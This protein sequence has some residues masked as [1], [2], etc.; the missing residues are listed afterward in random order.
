MLR[1]I[2]IFIL[3]LFPW[4]VSS[5]VISDYSY[6]NKLV[7]PFFAFNNLFYTISWTL[8]YIF[9][10]VSMCCLFGNYKFKD[11]PKS[12]K[13]SLIINYLFNQG[14]TLVFFGLK[15]NFLGF[16]F[17]LGTFVSSLFLFEEAN[18][19]IDCKSKLLYPN[20]ILS[21]YATILSL[22]IYFMNI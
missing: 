13:W 6:Y 22:T 21:L 16:V 15:N 18:Q 14:F 8:V 7:L 2:F 4:F 12:Y 17:C 9:N 19:L 1:K 11:I 10:A 20:I 5:L 3:C